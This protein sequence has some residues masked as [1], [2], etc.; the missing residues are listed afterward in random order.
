MFKT[1]AIFNNASKLI[2]LEQ[3]RSFSRG[4]VVLAQ[5]RPRN[6]SRVSATEYN[7]ER[8]HKPPGSIE[9]WE[10]HRRRD[11]SIQRWDHES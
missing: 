3:R 8:I 9:D 2:K 4:V 6:Y 7:P 5:T 10:G 1:K 11:D